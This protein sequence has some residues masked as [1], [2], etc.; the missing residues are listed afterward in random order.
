MTKT[1]HLKK[2]AKIQ[3]EFLISSPPYSCGE[4][5]LLDIVVARNLIQSGH[6][7]SVNEKDGEAV[8]SNFIPRRNVDWVQVQRVTKELCG[9]EPRTP[10]DAIQFL[11]LAAE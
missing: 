9:Q 4:Q 5:A 2:P 7:R 8:A 10:R 1:L 6:A 11:N 3:V